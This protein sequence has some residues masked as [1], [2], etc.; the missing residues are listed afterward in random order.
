MPAAPPAST[1]TGPTLR[2]ANLT[3]EPPLRSQVCTTGSTLLGPQMLATQGGHGVSP[4]LHSLYLL[5]VGSDL[6]TANHMAQV[7]DFWLQECTLGGLQ[8][9]SSCPETVKD[10]SQTTHMSRKVWGLGL[11]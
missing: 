7:C 9:Q 11:Q 10:L 1:A 4:L 2:S 5:R 3:A 6:V 8:L